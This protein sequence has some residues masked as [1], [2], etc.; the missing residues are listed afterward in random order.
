MDGGF[1]PTPKNLEFLRSKLN[2][3][4]GSPEF[5][6]SHRERLD[7][8]ELA[9]FAHDASLHNGPKEANTLHASCTEFRASVQDPLERAWIELRI[10]RALFDHVRFLP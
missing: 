5:K 6:D 10:R 7:A 8:C 2:D 4:Q 9:F 1:I 3:V